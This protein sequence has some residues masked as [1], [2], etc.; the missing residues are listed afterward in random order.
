MRARLSTNHRRTMIAVW[1]GRL[2]LSAVFTVN[3]Q[4]ALSF[5]LLPGQY[6]ASFELTGVGGRVA[7]QG[8]GIFIL[9]WVVPYP[10]AIRSPSRHILSFCYA[11]VSQAIG[12]L[13]E[14]AI[15]LTLPPGHPSLRA[16]GM[17]FILADTLGL[18]L[19]LGALV[20]VWRTVGLGSLLPAHRSRTCD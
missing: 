9:L 17:R 6:V 7:V 4:C 16:T 12:I 8:F 3:V 20:A 1:L 14:T 13:G 15:L 11:V 19:L 18:L 10:L 2:A 5:L